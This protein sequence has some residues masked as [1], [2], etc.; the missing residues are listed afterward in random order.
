VC[1]ARLA[2]YRR[3]TTPESLKAAHFFARAPDEFVASSSEIERNDAVSGANDFS[4]LV[5]HGGAGLASDP[6]STL[7]Y[8]VED[9]ANDRVIVLV[10]RPL[11]ARSEFG[12]SLG[13]SHVPFVK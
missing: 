13:V 9:F 6:F 8:I 10:W 4:C 5:A 1:V 2:V 3:A 7:E 12:C 11:K